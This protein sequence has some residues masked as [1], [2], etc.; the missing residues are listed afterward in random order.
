[1]SSKDEIFLM[2]IFIFIFIA[3]VV[4]TLTSGWGCKGHEE[5]PQ[6][7]ANQIWPIEDSQ[8]VSCTNV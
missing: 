8:N 6:A 4:T 2:F 1:M 3:L 5:E 7:S